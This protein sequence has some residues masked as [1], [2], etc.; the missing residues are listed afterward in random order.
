[1][2]K[3]TYLL[4][5]N[6]DNVSEWNVTPLWI[7]VSVDEHYK[8]P[9]K[10][11]LLAQSKR[12]SRSS[13]QKVIYSRHEELLTYLITHSPSMRPIQSFLNITYI[14]LSIGQYMNLELGGK[15]YGV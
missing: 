9:V 6:L 1:M 15:G 13:H 8:N 5:R 12:V 7:V 4:S 3:R 14:F 10:G 2:F 11:L